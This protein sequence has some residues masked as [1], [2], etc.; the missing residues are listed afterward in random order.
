MNGFW[1]LKCKKILCYGK[2]WRVLE[3]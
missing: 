1:P 2:L 3:L